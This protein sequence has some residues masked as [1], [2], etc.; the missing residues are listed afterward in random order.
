MTIAGVGLAAMVR[1]VIAVGGVVALIG[2]LEHQVRAVEEP[3][4]RPVHGAAYDRYTTH[5]GR[6]LSG[7]GGLPVGTGTSD[8]P[9]T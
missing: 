1:N 3:Y 8:Q 6:F 4:L 9:R 5:V 7:I 2:A